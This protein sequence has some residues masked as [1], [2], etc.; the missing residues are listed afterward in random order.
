MSRKSLPE[1]SVKPAVAAPNVKT[2]GGATVHAGCFARPC[3]LGTRDGQ[4]KVAAWCHE[5]TPQCWSFTATSDPLSCSNCLARLRKAGRPRKGVTQPIGVSRV[6]LELALELENRVL[7]PYSAPRRL[8]LSPSSQP[9]PGWLGKVREVHDDLAVMVS[10]ATP[11]EAGV[12]SGM[13]GLGVAEL[14]ALFADLDDGGQPA[15]A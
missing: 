12:V 14:A 13:I 3:C 6:R 8:R 10:A 15:A 2:N 9:W 7:I 11:A 4:V 5:D 1:F